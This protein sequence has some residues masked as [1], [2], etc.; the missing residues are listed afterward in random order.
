MSHRL[1]GTPFLTL[2]VVSVIAAGPLSGQQPEDAVPP[3]FFTARYAGIGYV[4]NAPNVF[5]GVGGFVIPFGS[6]GLYADGKLS[7]DTPR[8]S[9]NF[10]DDVTLEQVET[11]F[12]DVLFEERDTW[13]SA[14]LAAVRPI[15]PEIAAYAG[16]GITRRTGYREYFDPQGERGLGGYYWIGDDELN[17]LGPNFLA[18]VLLH[19]GPNLVFQ[20]GG[21]TSPIGA[22]LGIS[23]ALPF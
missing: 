23:Y 16:V 8:G 6:F 20:L 18:G 22:T 9:E 21:E 5:F 7:I 11:E 2:A 10:A 3:S 1:L 14:N 4:V 15:T 17:E 19:A 12:G 13:L